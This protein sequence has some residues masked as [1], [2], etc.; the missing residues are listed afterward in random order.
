[1]TKPGWAALVRSL[2]GEGSG[3]RRRGRSA[4]TQAAAGEGWG[5]G[6][7]RTR[8]PDDAAGP[9]HVRR[10][11]WVVP[12]H[13]DALVLRAVLG[14]VLAAL[15]PDHRR[16]VRLVFEPALAKGVVVRV[17]QAPA[18]GQI[19]EG[20]RIALFI[21]DVDFEDTRVGKEKCKEMKKNGEGIWEGTRKGTEERKKNEEG[22][23]EGARKAP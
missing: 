21:G 2:G 10:R 17:V 3:R 12:L 9:R 5:G 19:A 14:G 13:A 15:T 22:I 8:A 23:W 18:H 4:R 1:M 7:A 11:A 6:R 20:P 16:E